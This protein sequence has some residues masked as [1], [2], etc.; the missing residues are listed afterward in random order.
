M[1][2]KPFVLSCKVLVWNDDGECLLLRRS[3]ASK[4]NKGKWDLPGG[5]ADAG[6]TFDEALRRE[7]AEET[8][9]SILLD[10]VAGTAESDLPTRKVA[11]LI[12]AGRSRGGDIRLSEEHDAY[13]WVS[14]GEFATM[15]VCPQFRPFLEALASPSAKQG[16]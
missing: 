6:E 12:M 15:D 3:A 13:A 1:V 10:G 14:P 9:L 2:E 8:G 4:N 16:R 5:K 11:Y 7:V